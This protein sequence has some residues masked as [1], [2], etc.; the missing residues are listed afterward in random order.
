M[1][2]NHCVEVREAIE[3][4]A[5]DFAA[6][7]SERMLRRS[8]D[9]ADFERLAAAGYLR[10]GMPERSGGLW[11]GLAAS[12]RDYAEMVR[13]LAEGDACV[14]L[15]AAMHP[16]VLSFWLAVETVRV[17]DDAWQ[18]QRETCFTS[19]KA[20]HWWGT[21]ISE[22]GSGGDWLATRTRA[23]ADGE[24]YRLSGE[25][26]FGSGAGI[27]SFMITTA[28][29]DADGAPDFF[30]VDMRERAWDG[31]SG[32][33]LRTPWN[34]HG[35]IATQSH[36]FTLDGCPAVR[37]ASP[38]ALSTAAPVVAQL[39][40]MLF[41]AVVVGI[42]RNAVGLAR[43]RLRSR[44]NSLKAYEQVAWVELTNAAW[45]AEQAYEGALRAIEGGAGGA[46]ASA[47]AKASVAAL[48][49]RCLLDLARVL[50][51]ASYARDAPFGQWAED[52]RALGFLRPPWGLAFEQLLKLDFSKN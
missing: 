20:G 52:V 10:T 7:R 12:V 3:T 45:L 25:K 24:A 30:V 50:G 46:L 6:A 40:S 43:E 14:A 42:L 9:P 31:S 34:G 17:Q 38:D 13:V 47:R 5:K 27:T 49:E 1:S 22:P 51:G 48:A 41:V 37:A 4:I 2:S 35:M 11:R 16:S 18:R 32:L 26:H 19:A 15:V 21:M 29:V 33:T 23:G 28:R 44:A 8:L 39:T 36:A